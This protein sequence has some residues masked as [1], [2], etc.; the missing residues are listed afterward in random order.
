MSAHLLH[1][2]HAE[3][4]EERGDAPLRRFLASIGGWPV[5]D[6]T[7]S[8]RDFDWLK[9]I[10]TLRQ[11]NN[12]VLINQWI[13]SD[14]RNSSINIIQVCVRACACTISDNACNK[15]CLFSF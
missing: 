11:Y 2:V 6:A 10:A 9:L 8:E 3:A 15:Q 1:T 4:I 13:S 12:R 14:D 7:W 5:V